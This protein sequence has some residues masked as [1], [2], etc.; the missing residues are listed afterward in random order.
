MQARVI[1]DDNMLLKELS[2]SEFLNNGVDC[3]K[4]AIHPESTELTSDGCP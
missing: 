3:P 1:S 4:N 2:L